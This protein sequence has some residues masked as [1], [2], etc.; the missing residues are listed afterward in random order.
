MQYGT[1]NGTGM[2]KSATNSILFTD[3]IFLKDKN[4]Y[5]FYIL[6]YVLYES[7]LDPVSF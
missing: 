3:Y 7:E 1:R 5:I 6:L 2:L 4:S